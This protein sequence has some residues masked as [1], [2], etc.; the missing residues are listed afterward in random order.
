MRELPPA[1][2]FPIEPLGDISGP[3]V[4]AIQDRVDGAHKGLVLV[5]HRQANGV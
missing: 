3:A 1:V 2:P 5:S 4:L